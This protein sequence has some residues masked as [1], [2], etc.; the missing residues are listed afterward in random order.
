[1]LEFTVTLIP[2]IAEML[3]VK[4]S[5]TFQVREPCGQEVSVILTD[6]GLFEINRKGDTR[7]RDD[8]F[9][10]IICG[11]I[12][13]KVS[14]WKPKLDDK[15]YFPNAR[16]KKVDYMVWKEDITDLALCALGMCYRYE[17]EAE[18][19]FEKDLARLTGKGEE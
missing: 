10:Q 1:M 17:S 13:F 19:N 5:E 12:P 16:L 2:Q 9:R 14:K 3:G 4:L 18:K 8:Y 15:Y 11:V 7:R 6:E